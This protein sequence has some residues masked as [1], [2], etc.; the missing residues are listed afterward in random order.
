MTDDG[1]SFE[2]SNALECLTKLY[3]DSSRF[4]DDVSLNGFMVR[5]ADRARI[6]GDHVTIRTDT[7]D[8]FLQDLEITGLVKTIK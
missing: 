4:T 8:N 3:E 2:G 7:I 5:M 6:F 1:K